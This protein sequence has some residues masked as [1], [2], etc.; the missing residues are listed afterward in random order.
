LKRKKSLD[1]IEQYLVHY[2]GWNSTWDQWVNEDQLLDLN[3]ENL[4]EMEELK[5]IK[6]DSNNLYL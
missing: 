1:G 5:Q 6:Y 3:D 4:K 2:I